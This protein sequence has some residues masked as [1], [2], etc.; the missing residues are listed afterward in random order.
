MRYL[1][2]LFAVASLVGAQVHVVDQSGLVFVDSVSGD[3]NTVI[4]TG[5]TV[6]WNHSF[7]SHTVTSG[8]GAAAANSGLLF[9]APL[10]G[11]N[12]T[13]SFTFNTPG[14]VP[15][16]CAPH[17]GFGMTGTITVVDDFLAITSPG[18]GAVDINLAAFSP[19]ASWQLLVSFAPQTPTGSGFLF[20]VGGDAWPQLMNPLFQGTIDGTGSDAVFISGLPA[21]ISVDVVVLS[22]VGNS[23]DGV[24]NVV[25]FTTQ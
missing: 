7:G 16:Y 10:N 24:S 9:D 19:G 3:S 5:T 14:V 23:L 11:A 25:A 21:G 22:V 6:Q 15:Y 2:A 20:G 18:P 12:P 13:F 8:T 17:E 4:A 1:I